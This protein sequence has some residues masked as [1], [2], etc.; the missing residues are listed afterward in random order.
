[1]ESTDK[2]DEVL[3]KLDRIL[4]ILLKDIPPHKHD[5][6]K[7]CEKKCNLEYYS[8]HV[9]NFCS[10]DSLTLVEIMRHENSPCKLR[11]IP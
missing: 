1:M 11:F 3:A 4:T 8:K 2:L 7:K 10:K 5:C 6:E 9:C